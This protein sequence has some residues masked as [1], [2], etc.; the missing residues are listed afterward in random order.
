M[1]KFMLVGKA[2]AGKS[3]LSKKLQ[4]EMDFKIFSFA[5]RLKQIAEE[6][7]MAPLD[8]INDPL[9]DRWLLQQLGTELGRKYD[10]DLWVKQLA[11]SIKDRYGGYIPDFENIVIDDCRFLNEAKWGRDNG[12]IIVRVVGRGYELDPSLANHASEKEQE[13]IEVDYTVDN[14][15]S[16]DDTM[17]ALWNIFQIES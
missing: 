16:L 10:P 3:T 15:G 9:R 13:L 17:Q 11:K 7:K 4:S 14:S 6:I 5:T 2:G 1:V 8:K 12:F